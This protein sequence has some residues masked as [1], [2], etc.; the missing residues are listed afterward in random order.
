[1]TSLG[2]SKIPNWVV[3]RKETGFCKAALSEITS[4]SQPIFCLHCTILYG[5]GGGG[6]KKN[7][8]RPCVYNQK[9]QIKSVQAHPI[10]A[11][12]NFWEPSFSQLLGTWIYTI[13]T[14]ARKHLFCLHAQNIKLCVWEECYA[15]LTYSLFIFIILWSF[16]V[17]PLFVILM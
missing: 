14:Y 15:S 3:G 7:S 4:F 10:L 12:P 1:M 11:F 16:F 2:T 9:G 5:G 8:I 17:Y 13:H 6:V